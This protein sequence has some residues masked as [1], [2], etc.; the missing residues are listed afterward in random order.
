MATTAL[1]SASNEL[2]G[3]LGEDMARA[4]AALAPPLQ[5]SDV[6]RVAKTL[7]ECGGTAE[8][9][10]VAALFRSDVDRVTLRNVLEALQVLYEFRWQLTLERS[11]RA[12][13]Q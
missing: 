4:L 2:R 9:V 13:E 12:G 1:Q 10:D 11:G 7:S 5:T 8:D 3:W 6:L